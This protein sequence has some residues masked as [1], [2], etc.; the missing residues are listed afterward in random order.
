MKLTLNGNERTVEGDTTV[1]TLLDQLEVG[2]TGVAVAVNGA[3]VPRS[4]HATHTLTENDVVEVIRAVGG[5]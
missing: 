2:R 4:N 1:A 3:V 5:G